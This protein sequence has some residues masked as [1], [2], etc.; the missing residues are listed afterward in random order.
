MPARVIVIGLDSMDPPL[1]ERWAGEG[2]LPAIAGVAARG[3]SYALDSCMRTLPASIWAE[4]ASGRL[5]PRIGWTF[6]MRHHRAGETSPR[7]IEPGE[8]DPRAFWTAA[9]DAG[10]R[11]AAL[12][13][14]ISVP[15]ASLGGIF[16][17]G[18]SE[19]D[20]LFGARSIP[21]GLAAE[22]DA[23]H[24]PYP[25]RSCDHD[26]ERSRAGKERLLGCV[27]EGV[28]RSAACYLELLGR[29][30]WDLFACTFGQPQCVGHHYWGPMEE[31]PAPG[32]P[33]ATRFHTAVLD[34][35]QAIDRAVG[36]LV[37]AAGPD[38]AVVLIPSHGMGHPVGGYHLLPEVLV[39]LGMGSGTGAAARVR[40]RLPRPVRRAIRALVPG[41]ARTR[42]QGAAGSL[43]HPLD[44]P[45]TRAVAVESSIVGCIRVNLRG[46]EPFGRVEPG[47]EADALL[48]ELRRELLALVDPDTG[49]RLVDQVLAADELMPAG[50]RSPDVAD[51]IVCF[52]QDIGRIEA[53]ASPRVGTVRIPFRVGDRT[54]EHTTASRVVVAGRGVGG[55]GAGLAGHAVDVAP[56]VLA[57]LGVDTPAWMDGRP[58]PLT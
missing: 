4:L 50:E 20:I 43:Q 48:G 16:L 17:S 31:A 26:F 35:Y 27:L 36:A 22:V 8:V 49:V 25:V 33:L 29:E 52:R 7:Q 56:T 10:L 13:M 12:D 21:P 9:S 6:P 34:V 18:W 57:L 28:E 14:P 41:G 3:R 15:P 46:R 24:G 38:A 54:G 58:L 19:H 40:S 45:D 30:P 42:L 23:R 37:E 32:D 1:V 11:V 47:P 39:R 53:C 51:L 2:L 5:A 55:P 44:S